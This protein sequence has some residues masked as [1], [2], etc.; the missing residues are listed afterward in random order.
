MSVPRSGRN[1]VNPAFVHGDGAVIGLAG[2]QL[3]AGKIRRRKVRR[4]A[5]RMR[6]GRGWIS[7]NDAPAFA[8]DVAGI[9]LAHQLV[10][11]AFPFAEAQ[12]PS[13]A[14]LY[15]GWLNSYEAPAAIC[16]V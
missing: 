6:G 8:L 14:P 4:R 11:R 2:L 15:T 9:W 10:S 7:L 1:E 12:M 16:T 13:T 5:Q 3:T